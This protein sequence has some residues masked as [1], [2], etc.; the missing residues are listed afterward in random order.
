MD[1]AYSDQQWFEQFVKGNEQGLAWVFDRHSKSLIAYVC[2]IVGD[3]DEAEDIVMDMFIKLWKVRSS[4]DGLEHL[5]PMLFVMC[6]NKAFSALRTRAIL[7]AAEKEWLLQQETADNNV[8]ARMMKYYVLD[9]LARIA[10]TM[11]EMRARVY[12]DFHRKGYSI[13]AIADKYGIKVQTVRN[14]LAQAVAQLRGKMLRKDLLISLL[15]L[16]SELFRK[17]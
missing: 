5:R 14:H 15:L 7:S 13:E 2:K 6:R 12:D 1:P 9:E 10:A 11:P 17:N 3:T 8:D 4:V 16:I